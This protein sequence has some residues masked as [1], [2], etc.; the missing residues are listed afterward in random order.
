M[1]T[2]IECIIKQLLVDF[3]WLN[4]ASIKQS[5]NRR[6]VMGD[7]ILTLSVPTPQNG[8]THSNYSSAVADK[9]FE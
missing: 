3:Y 6:Y 1:Q 8:Q 5:N 4:R 7:N 2:Q 9:L